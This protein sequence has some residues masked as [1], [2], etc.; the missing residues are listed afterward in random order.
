M[1]GA[2]AIMACL[3]AHFP[4]S[5]SRPLYVRLPA[6]SDMSTVVLRCGECP[7]RQKA[8]LSVREVGKVRYKPWS[9]NRRIMIPPRLFR[10]IHNQALHR[11]GK[12]LGKLAVH[13]NPHI[14]DLRGCHHLR[15][16]K[17]V[18]VAVHT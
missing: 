13:H 11:R 18:D 5:R 3:A 1:M 4:P 15:V 16:V 8:F 10:R 7:Q 6:A 12:G 14:H 9:E 17:L 2:D